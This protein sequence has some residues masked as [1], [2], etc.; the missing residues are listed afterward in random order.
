[1]RNKPIAFRP[2]D[3]ALAILKDYIKTKK[4]SQAL[5]IN[6]LIESTVNI[7]S[8]QTPKQ[9]IQNPCIGTYCPFRDP[10]KLL[11]DE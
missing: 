4:V 7:Q 1:M 8:E 2:S 5:A 9:S 11:S 3:K 6:E 10:I